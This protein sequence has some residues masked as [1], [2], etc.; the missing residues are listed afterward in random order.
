MRP[1]H[2]AADRLH[3]DMLWWT[4]GA[5]TSER[6]VHRRACRVRSSRLPSLPQASRSC[7]RPPPS[8]STRSLQVPTEQGHPAVDFHDAVEASAL[9]GVPEEFDPNADTRA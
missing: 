3:L 5:E 9:C 7:D 1:L 6:E 8:A 4:A 2:P